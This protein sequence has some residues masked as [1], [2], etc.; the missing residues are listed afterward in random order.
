MP[1]P[2]WKNSQRGSAGSGS[3]SNISRE[4][5]QLSVLAGPRGPEVLPPAEIRFDAYPEGKPRIVDY[6]A[7]WEPDSFEYR[8]TNRSFEFAAGDELRIEGLK[9][10][11]AACW[12][13]F[14]LRGYARVDFRMDESGTPWILEINAN[15]CLAPDGGFP[16]AA[17]RAGISLDRLWKNCRDL[18]I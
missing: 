9:E 10:A 1:S 17:C 5:I 7:K 18:F 12:K 2:N 15:P 11:S 13:L 3:A 16:A 14:D 8:H 4:R 6:R